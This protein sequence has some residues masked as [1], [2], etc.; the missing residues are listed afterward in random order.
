MALNCRAEIQV[1]SDTCILFI[2]YQFILGLSAYIYQWDL[3]TLNIWVGLVDSWVSGAICRV[4]VVLL[5][6]SYCYLELNLF[7]SASQLSL[8]YQLFIL[9]DFI[10]LCSL[11]LAFVNLCL[12]RERFT[13]ILVGLWKEL[14]LYA[15]FQ[16]IAFL[17]ILSILKYNLWLFRYLKLLGSIL[18]FILSADLSEY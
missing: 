4:S 11:F 1:Q 5:D 15:C 12:G 10:C 3:N 7:F 14:E 16:Y 13:I 18:L 6:F 17:I 2:R 8:V 9:Q